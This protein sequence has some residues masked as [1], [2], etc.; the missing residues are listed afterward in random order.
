M[1]IVLFSDVHANLPALD[2]FWNDIDIIDYDLIFCLGDLVGYNIWPNEVIRGIRDRKIPT[3]M[4]N[5]DEK[6]VGVAKDDTEPK[7]YA[8]NVIG[9]VER[10]YLS[11]LPAHIQLN[12][13]S[14]KSR[15]LLVHGS[16]LS[17]KE[18]ITEETSDET[19]VKYCRDFGVNILCFGHTHKPFYREIRKEHVVFH[20]INIGSIGKPK[21]GNPDG[22]YACLELNNGKVKVEI[23]RFKYN[24]E[25]ASKAVENSP[26][27]N[28]LAEMLRAGC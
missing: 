3:I 19:I 22:C 26:L 24:I 6:A 8:Y 21:D 9:D 14:S 13:E 12:F 1:R 16:P 28:E 10:S 23:K 15:L 18:Y 4:G 5:H 17:N 2:A 7:N 11:D 25:R 20:A 27:P